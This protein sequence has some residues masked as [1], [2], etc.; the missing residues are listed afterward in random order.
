MRPERKSAVYL[1]PDGV[2]EE[3][4]AASNRGLCEPAGC[5]MRV[6]RWGSVLPMTGFEP[7]TSCST[8]V[9]ELPPRSPKNP[10]CVDPTPS[11]R[12]SQAL[13]THRGFGRVMA[14]FRGE[15]E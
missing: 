7:V 3:G 13:P 9:C 11:R 14:V 10:I 5:C 4:Y 2:T 12:P 6:A 15:K 8:G 1:A